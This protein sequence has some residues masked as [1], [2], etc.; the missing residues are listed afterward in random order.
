MAT[1]EMNERPLK[2]PENY[3]FSTRKVDWKNFKDSYI[4]RTDAVW[5][6]HK[7]YAYFYNLYK[8]VRNILM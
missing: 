7:L 8:Y 3:D 2:M 1:I 6:K 4:L 5:E